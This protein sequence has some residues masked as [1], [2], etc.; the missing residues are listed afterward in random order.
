MKKQITKDT[1]EH[2]LS[3]AQS[4]VRDS[5]PH[6]SGVVSSFSEIMRLAIKGYE[7]EAAQGGG[8]SPTAMEPFPVLQLGIR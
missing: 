8:E 4:A 7:L 5:F 3:A 6:N 1:L 2:Y